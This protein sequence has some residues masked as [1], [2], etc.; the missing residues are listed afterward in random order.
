MVTVG[1]A[2]VA[3]TRMG[4]SADRDARERLAVRRQVRSDRLLWWAAAAAGGWLGLFA[5]LVWV[6]KGRPAFGEFVG[7]VVYLVPD[8]ACV[9]LAVVAAWV[10]RGRA[11]R[12]W[13]LLAGHNILLL[14][15][16]VIWA[17][18]AYLTPDGIPF[19][20]VA[21]AAYL[22]AYLLAVPAM[23]VGFGG[24]SRVRRTRGLLDTALVL[25]GIGAV[26]WQVFVGPQL[27]G[28]LTLAGAVGAAYPLADIAVVGCL[29]AIGLS[30]HRMVPYAVLLTG[31]AFV[32]SAATDL[33]YTYLTFFAAYEDDSW[34]NL[35]WQSSAVLLC[36][37]ALV[38]IRHR[39][40]K[41][42]VAQLDRT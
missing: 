41:P 40:A 8:V 42:H 16:D 19:P 3:A 14:T 34:L 32:L 24:S 31:A 11:R 15:G 23:L 25:A 39:E 37:S 28:S 7:D 20:S 35:G 17:G 5:V 33:G 6:G 2:P 18:Y 38:A 30:G 4:S 26:G 21:D 1:E 12:L 22:S 10:S 9:V 27:A 13:A 29:I 36:L